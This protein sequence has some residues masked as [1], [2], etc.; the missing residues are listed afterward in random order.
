MSMTVSVRLSHKSPAKAKGQRHHDTRQSHIPVYVDKER[1]PLNSVVIEP[2]TERELRDIC[3]DRRS[4]RATKRAMKK[5]A[6][7]STVG[8]ITFGKEAQETIR[9]L[10]VAEQN[11]LYLQTAKRIA[12]KLGTDVTGLVVHRDES[13]PHAHFQMPAYSMDGIPV[14]KV[15]TPTLAKELQ[16]AA[17]SVYTHLDIRRGTP[18]ADRIE[19]GEDV[20][21][22]VHRSVKRLHNDLPIEIESL[23]RDALDA[24]VS[25]ERN[26]HLAE[27]ARVDLE[28]LREEISTLRIVHDQYLFSSEEE[29][30]DAPSPS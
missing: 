12:L 20:A 15:L 18:K 2:K 19:R 10:S 23:R 24:A 30:D 11:A 7:I 9:Q 21:Q 13:A 28:A 29:E 6:A 14:S 27:K 16:D 1:S 22:T 25:A 3:L 26:R 4:Q 17:G 8:I 5:D